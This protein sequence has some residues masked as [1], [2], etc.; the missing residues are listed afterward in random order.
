MLLGVTMK[1]IESL[2]KSHNLLLFI[3]NEKGKICGRP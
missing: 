1:S 2:V 3:Y